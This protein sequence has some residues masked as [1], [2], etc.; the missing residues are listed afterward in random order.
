M[1]TKCSLAH[2]PGFHLYQEV[3][4]DD[5]IYLEVEGTH[6]EAAYKRVMLPI[7]V[8]VWEVIRHYPGIS[9]KYADKTDAELRDEVACSVDERLM[10]YKEASERAAPLHRFAGSLV[11]GSIDAPREEQ[12]AQGMAY[13]TRMRAHQ[14]QI[15]HAVEEL[16]QMQRC[17]ESFD[18]NPESDLL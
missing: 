3:F 5:N 17:S 18:T 8:H 10:K 2:G 7:P 16:E 11:F 1:S 15:R 14:Q 12:I 9:Y 13:F 4:D 6:F